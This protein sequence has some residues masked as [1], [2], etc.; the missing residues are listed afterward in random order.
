L[1]RVGDGIVKNQF[2][3]DK[4]D[5]FKY[6]LWL[7]IAERM[8]GIKSLTLVPML[9]PDDST[10]EGRITSYTEGKRRKRLYGFLQFCLVPKR[11]SI[12]RLREFLR[13]E[14]F[15]YH[16]YRDMDDKGFQDGSW[17]AYF[18][19]V[20]REW[21]CDAATLID[22]DIGLER[23][24]GSRNEHPEKYFTC[25]NIANV[26]GRCSG[27]SVVVVFQ[28]LQ[29][30]ANRREG[31]LNERGK[32]LHG[33]LRSVQSY[34]GPVRWVAEKIRTGL[35]Q[36]AFF[37]IGAGSESPMSLDRVLGKYGK[38]HDLCVGHVDL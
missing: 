33:T 25:E 22:P 11:R 13:D 32:R 36:L 20:P 9:I 14:P 16:P 35:G 8:P 6:D 12:T 29:N 26:V 28:F 30:N 10:N 5:Y 3:A 24:K 2:F 15:E 38:T 31:D 7:D 19:A 1:R 18:N 21:L 4:R 23:K 37:V 27:N 17:D 34:H